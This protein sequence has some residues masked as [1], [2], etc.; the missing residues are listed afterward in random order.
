MSLGLAALLGK[1]SSKIS[2]FSRSIFFRW[3][4]YLCDLF[5]GYYWAL[6]ILY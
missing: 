6:G 2:N 1:P 5:L 4:W 3:S